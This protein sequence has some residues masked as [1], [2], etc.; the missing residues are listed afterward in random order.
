MNKKHRSFFQ[1]KQCKYCKKQAT[2]FRITKSQPEMLCD[3]YLCDKQSRVS[4]GY[5]KTPGTKQ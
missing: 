2:L 5:F 4:A 3:A 1:N